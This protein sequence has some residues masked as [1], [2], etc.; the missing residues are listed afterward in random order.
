VR[1]PPATAISD[2]SG[3]RSSPRRLHR[4]LVA[5]AALAALC[6]LTAPTSAHPGTRPR[7]AGKGQAAP[8]AGVRVPP[9]FF[10]LHD[11]SMA[12]YDGLDVGSVRLWDAGVEW[13]QVETSPGI[14][15]WTRLDAL[16]EAAQ[17]HGTEVTLVLAMTPSFDGPAA[18][19]PPTDFADYAAYVRAVMSRYRDF[20]G[21]RGIAAYQVWNEGNVPTFWQGTPAEL[22]WMTQVVDQV[23]DEVD[24]AAT[25]V[26]PAFAVRYAGEQSWVSRYESQ[27]VAGRPVWSFYDAG[28]FSLYPMATYGDRPG[29]PEDAMSLLAEVRG[30]LGDAGVPA[31]KPVWATEINYGLKSGAPGRLSAEPISQRQQVAN[32]LRTYLLGASRGLSRIFWYRYDWG[33]LP[34]SQGGGTL[35]NTLLTTPGQWDQITPA[36]EAL[37]TA[38]NWLAGR[39]VAAGSRR[40]CAHDRRGTFTCVVRHAG[41][42]RTIYWNPD[43]KVSVQVRGAVSRQAS[44]GRTVAMSGKVARVTVGF[45]PVAVLTR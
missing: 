9:A 12:A 29:G 13:R 14:Y 24:P 45:Q 33:R 39:L 31:T 28:A 44:N 26:A 15:D 23:R 32:V 21:S 43:R 19:L 2:R 40:P 37:T 25:V 7:T 17:A 4:V 16:V 10:G 30:V 27:R 41:V 11:G 20:H 18:N 35:G 5:L 34:D 1:T 36:G 8:V 3:H 22:A 6:S 38:Q 42:T